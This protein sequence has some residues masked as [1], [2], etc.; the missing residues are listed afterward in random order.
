VTQQNEKAVDESRVAETDGTR[1]FDRKRSY[2]IQITPSTIW[3]GTLLALVV[4]VMIGVFEYLLAPVMVNDRVFS[5]VNITTEVLRTTCAITVFGV[6]WLTRRFSLDIRSLTIAMAFLAAGILTILRLLTFP[7]MPSVSGSS[8]DIDHSLYLTVFLRYTIGVAMLGSVFIRKQSQTSK[9]GIRVAIFATAAYLVAVTAIVLAPGNPL[10][11]IQQGGVLLHPGIVEMELGAICVSY[12]AAL[13]YAWIAVKDND[14][15]YALVSIG[16]ILYAQA[17]FAF[18]QSPTSEDAVFLVGRATALVGFFLV[19]LAVMKTSLYLPYVKLESATR[20]FGLAKSE[21]IKKTEEMRALAQ[22][23]TERRL[24]EA[25]L[26]KSEKSYRDLVETATEGV[27]RIDENTKT[28]FVNRQMAEMLGYSVEEIEGTAMSDFVEPSAR[29]TF[30]QHMDSRRK[31]VKERYELPFVR[32]DGRVIHGLI[33]ATPAFDEIGDFK[34]STAFVTDITERKR[35]EDALRASER[36][37]FRFLV[38]LPVGIVVNDPKGRPLFSNDKA[39]QILGAALD[40]SVAD[41][42]VV[43]FRQGHVAGTDRSY[44]IDRS[45]M[46]RALK[47]E[48]SMVDDFEIRRGTE[49][50]QLEIWGTPVTDQNGQVLYGIVAFQ[51]ITE[52]KKSEQLI[53]DLNKSLEIHAKRLADINKELETFSYSVSHDLRA[54]L[55]TI[56]GFSTIL[57]EHHSGALDE[58]GKDYLNRVRAGCQRMG[59]LIDD[60]LK[61]SRITRDEMTWEKV[62]LS[63]IARSVLA[64]IRK[65]QPERRVK[66]SIEDGLVVHG[67]ARLYRILMTNLLENAWKFCQKQPRPVIEF[68]ATAING[69]RVLFV[70]DNGAGFD[71]KHAGRLFVPFQRLHSSV[72]FAGTGIGLATAQRIVYRHGGRIWAEGEVGKGATFYFTEGHGGSI[73]ATDA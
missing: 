19:F 16:M 37:L 49:N 46:T 63:K 7:Q 48:S 14:S 69:E 33:S 44:P 22:D 32:K 50:V 34:G 11:S 52:R 20:E 25:A 27:W 35:S 70:K 13:G 47:G 54:P 12:I 23:L 57:L 67:D 6:V 29:Q 24:V 39:R 28:V 18:L 60:M 58:K 4:S 72:E 65:A 30:G 42:A 5:T 1:R 45:P 59:Q 55:R 2:S 17:G 56:D 53:I 40:T 73:S 26:R 41:D 61:L 64:E 8:E 66:L 43:A 38:D 31:G 15:R 71:M 62:D 3:L 10:P 21:V 51:D 9:K 36:M 68:G